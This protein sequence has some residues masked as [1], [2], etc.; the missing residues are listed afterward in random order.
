MTLRN[1]T[2]TTE[3]GENLSPGKLAYTSDELASALGLSD[4]RKVDELRKAG[5]LQGI[6]VGRGYIYPRSEAERFLT[7][8]LGE[9]LSTHDALVLAKTLHDKRRSK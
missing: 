3:T 8:Y 9:D 6:K 2:P 1:D 7:D 5:V 4:R